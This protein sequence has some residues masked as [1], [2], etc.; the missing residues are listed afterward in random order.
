M[1]EQ[2]FYIFCTTL[3]SHIIPLCPVL[4]LPVAFAKGGAAGDGR[5]RT[6]QT[7]RCRLVHHIRCG[8]TQHGNRVLG[9]ELPALLVFPAAGFFQA[10]VYLSAD[11]GLSVGHPWNRG[12]SGRPVLS[13]FAPGMDGQLV[14]CSA[15]PADPSAAAPRL[16]PGVRA[17]I[18][19]PV[20]R[21][22][23]RPSGWFRPSSRR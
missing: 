2:L 16:S 14:L 3:P 21:T 9:V 19:T 10:A 5:Q 20:R 11:C 18:P 22:S 17:G 23:G 7:G 15:L 13:G 8:D 12:L 1:M 4:E 6:V